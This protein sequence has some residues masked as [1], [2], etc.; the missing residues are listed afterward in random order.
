MTVAETEEQVIMENMEIYSEIAT[1]TGK[2]SYTKLSK[3]A[4]IFGR[5]LIVFQLGMIVYD[6]CESDHPV[7]TAVE[8]SAEF[9]A[10]FAAG[11]AGEIIGTVA[12][13]SIFI[14]AGIATTTAL[15]SVVVLAASVVTGI[16]LAVAVGALTGFLITKLFESGGKTPK[17]PKAPATVPSLKKSV[18]RHPATENLV[19]HFAKMPAAER[20]A[21]RLTAA[22]A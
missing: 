2:R 9:G 11:I 4:K 15:A 19:I 5:A 1:K 3:G 13:E 18:V 7:Q 22:S 17:A 10:S 16:G 21:R 8:E 14:A 6:T 12:V 20:L